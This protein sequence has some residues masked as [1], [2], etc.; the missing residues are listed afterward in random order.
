MIKSSNMKGAG[1]I[2]VIPGMK[3]TYKVLFGKPE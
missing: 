1:Y 3:N 2:E